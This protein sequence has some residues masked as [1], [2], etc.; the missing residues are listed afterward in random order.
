MKFIQDYQIFLEALLPSQIRRYMKVFDR[1]RYS[2]IFN[3]Y[4][5]DKN[6]YRKYLPLNAK[7]K[8]Q[9]D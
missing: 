1:E 9:D 8:F 5:C 2:E 4:D 3:K 6:H 7:H